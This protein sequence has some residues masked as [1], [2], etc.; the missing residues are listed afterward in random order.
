MFNTDG[1]G[2]G[3]LVAYGA[4]AVVA[5]CLL[6]VDRS[7]FLRGGGEGGIGKEAWSNPGRGCGAEGELYRCES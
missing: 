5:F 6:G 3:G 7:D 1:G 2:E 4:R